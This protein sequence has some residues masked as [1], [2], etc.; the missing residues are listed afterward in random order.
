V[1][2]RFPYR[3]TKAAAS[4][5]W[6]WI[7]AGGEGECFGRG[8]ALVLGHGRAGFEIDRTYVTAG[9]PEHTVALASA[10]QFTDAY[11]TA[12]ERA[13]AIAPWYGGSDRR[14]G[15]RADMTVTPDPTAALSLRPGQS[16]TPRRFVSMTIGVTPRQFSRTSSM[17]FWPI[18]LLTGDSWS[19]LMIWSAPRWTPSD[20]K[21]SEKSATFSPRLISQSQPRLGRELHE[22][23]R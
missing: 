21:Q 9:T 12:I 15:L 4:P 8:P 17:A 11:Q 13:T 2:I 23:P 22:L 14:S 5:M 6:S 20:A 10:D 3:K 7:F 16:P 19:A 1:A 18:V